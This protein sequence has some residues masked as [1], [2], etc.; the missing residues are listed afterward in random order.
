MHQLLHYVYRPTISNIA[1]V[2]RVKMSGPGPI[3]AGLLIL[4][5]LTFSVASLLKNSE[6]KINRTDTLWRKFKREQLT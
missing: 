6:Y 4:R 2:I 1:R 3:P 5:P